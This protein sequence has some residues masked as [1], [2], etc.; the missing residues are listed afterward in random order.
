MKT[1]LLLLYL[2]QSSPFQHFIRAG[3]LQLLNLLLRMSRPEPQVIIGVRDRHCSSPGT[4]RGEKNKRTLMFTF[5]LYSSTAISGCLNPQAKP[6]TTHTLTHTSVQIN[7]Y[8][9]RF[10]YFPFNVNLSF[11]Y[12]FF[13]QFLI[14]MWIFPFVYHLLLH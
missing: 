8:H 7:P 13:T 12:L 10:L 9:P 14:N 5:L 2:V 3:L 6:L 4:G 1:W 11:F